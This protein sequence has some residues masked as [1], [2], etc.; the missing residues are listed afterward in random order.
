LRL[1]LRRGNNR[2]QLQ[3]GDGTSNRTVDLYEPTE[4]TSLPL[5]PVTNSKVVV[6]DAAAGGAHTLISTVEGDVYAVGS[7]DHGQLGVG[8]LFDRPKFTLVASFRD[9]PGAYYNGRDYRKSMGR[10][11]I[12]KLAAGHYTSAA[13]TDEGKL[14]TWGA[15]NKG[16]LGHGCAPLAAKARF[17]AWD[18]VSNFNRPPQAYD[19]GANQIPTVAPD[20][21]RMI[22]ADTLVNCFPSQRRTV[23]M[24]VEGLAHTYVSKVVMSKGFGVA[25]THM[26]GAETFSEGV[27]LPIRTTEYI[28]VPIL[29]RIVGKT[30]G[31]GVEMALAKAGVELCTCGQ[32]YM[33]GTN[34]FGQLGQGDTRSRFEPT[35]IRDLQ[36]LGIHIMDVALG[37]HHVI[38]LSTRGNVYSWGYNANGQLGTWDTINRAL[39]VRVKKRE[40][41][42]LFVS[43]ISA[44]AYHSVAVSDRGDIYT[45]GSNRNGQLAKGQA[46]QEPHPYPEMIEDFPKVR[47][48]RVICGAY[49]CLAVTLSLIFYSWGWNDNGQL[50]DGNTADLLAPQKL[51][52]PSTVP[53]FPVVFS[54]GY[55]H[56]IVVLQT[57]DL[58]YCGVNRWGRNVCSRDVQ[59]TDSIT[60]DEGGIWWVERATKGQIIVRGNEALEFESSGTVQLYRNETDLGVYP[61]TSV[62]NMEGYVFSFESI[63]LAFDTKG[64]AADAVWKTDLLV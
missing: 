3:F 1:S 5:S 63:D 9:A 59:F 24:L 19:T 6:V 32:V 49:H 62:R 41:G 25:L 36:D 57:G 40:P 44:G 2:G 54:C 42:F 18:D 51:S 15:D 26:C 48:M 29:G 22:D 47:G 43:T 14:Y 4:L 13:I 34:D 52:L 35:L 21:R 45:F 11:N 46:D 56:S 60:S 55:T 30:E 17:D 50:G 53:G 61:Y 16:Q 28:S 38:A 7:N 33:W 64:F 27:C 12:K 8:D 10:Q 23:P 20:S 31:S 39:P 37:A 58:T